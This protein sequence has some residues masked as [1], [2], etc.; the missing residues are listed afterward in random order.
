MTTIPITHDDRTPVP[1]HNILYRIFGQIRQQ[2]AQRHGRVLTPVNDKAARVVF[3]T[4]VHAVLDVLASASNPRHGYPIM[5]VA[6]LATGSGKSTS[7]AALVA[8]YATLHDD[9]RGLPRDVFS[10]AFVVPTVQLARET[11]AEI[12]DLMPQGE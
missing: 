8:A 1:Y 6:S 10:A 2:Q 7:A 5:R 4:G 12:A 3:E 11:V 9:K